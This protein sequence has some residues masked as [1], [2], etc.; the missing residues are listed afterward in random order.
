MK[1]SFCKST[2]PGLV[3]VLCGLGGLSAFAGDSQGTL[4]DGARY[5]QPKFKT[6]VTLTEGYDD[7]ALTAHSNPVRSGFTAIQANGFADLGSPRTAFT[8]GIGGGVTYYYSRPGRKYDYLASLNLNLAHKVT[9]RFTISLG[10]YLT[11]QVEPDYTLLVAQNRVNG[12]YFYTGDT[13]S[14]TYQ[15]TRRFSTVTSYQLVGIFYEDQAARVAN[16]YV[17]Q[18]FA[19][20]FRFLLLPTTTLVGEYRLGTVNYMY[21]T[22]RDVLTNYFLVGVDHSFTPKFTV[23]MRVGGEIQSQ[24]VGGSFSSPYGEATLTYAYQKLS[25]IQGYVRYGFDY[26][27]VTVNQTNRALRMGFQLN[28]GISPK[29]SFYLGCFYEHDDFSSVPGFAGSGYTDDSFSISTGIRYTITPRLTLQLGYVRSQLLS[30]QTTL[31]YHRDVASIGGTY[32][33]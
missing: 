1:K 30:D 17:A 27:N 11:Y 7:N 31:E 29:L 22:D 23:S 8:V 4:L 24:K 14:A 2:L 32:S 33:F 18:T 25:N 28:H 21:G 5:S 20:Q 3:F 9:D 26:S 16:D 13:L 15:W 6:T 10:A 19:N 12:Q